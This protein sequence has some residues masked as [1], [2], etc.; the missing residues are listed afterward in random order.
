MRQ[1][2]LLEIGQCRGV[3]FEALAIE[4]DHLFEQ[5]LIGQ[6]V[7]GWEVVG[8]GSILLGIEVG[9]CAYR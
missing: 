3:V 6:T 7:I 1:A 2:P 8:H 9:L 5:L 4:Q